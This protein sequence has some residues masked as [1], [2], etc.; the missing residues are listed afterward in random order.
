MRKKLSVFCVAF[1]ICVFAVS[2]ESQSDNSESDTSISKTETATSNNKDNSE[3]KLSYFKPNKNINDFFERYNDLSERPIKKEEIEEGNI[4]TKAIVYYDD[5]SME[6]ID[7]NN[8][9]L[10]ISIGANPE[11]EYDGFRDMFFNCI[12]AMKKDLSED[13]ITKAWD[14]IHNSGYIVEKYNLQDIEINYIP[15]KELSQSH[16]DLRI[17]MSF[18]I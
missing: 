18:P 6:I 9:F 7:S 1:I 15:Y 16:S 5:Y 17:D 11:N 3:E 10:S 8:G 13:Q 2:C 14:D 4:N 12:K